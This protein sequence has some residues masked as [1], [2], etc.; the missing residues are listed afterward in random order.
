MGSGALFAGEELGG[1]GRR[2]MAAVRTLL[3]MVVMPMAKNATKA[4]IHV[5]S[6]YNIVVKMFLEEN[7]YYYFGALK[8]K[9]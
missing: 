4:S 2:R 1:G 8:V 9:K 7:Q 5:N 6:M 3:V